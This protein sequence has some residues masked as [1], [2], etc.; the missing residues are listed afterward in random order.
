MVQAVVE[1]EVVVEVVVGVEVV[2]EV[3][4]E[5]VVEVEDADVG[6]DVVVVMVALVGADA[7]EV[8][9]IP[10]SEYSMGAVF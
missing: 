7:D 6:E 4:V 10:R 8:A 3:V 5:A 1:V 9:D 2:V